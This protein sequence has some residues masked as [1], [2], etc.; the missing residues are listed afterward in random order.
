V[1]SQVVFNLLF[2]KPPFLGTQLNARQLSFTHKFINLLFRNAQQLSD[3]LHSKQAGHFFPPNG[4]P[5]FEI[6]GAFAGLKMATCL[7]GRNFAFFPLIPD[8]QH[9]PV[10]FKSLCRAISDS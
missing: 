10:F 9:Y 2:G 6:K 8:N 7:C 3:F 4:T 1:G 5:V